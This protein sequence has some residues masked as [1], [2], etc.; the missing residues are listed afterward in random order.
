MLLVIALHVLAVV[1]WVGGMA[2]ALFILRP[3]LAALPPPQRLAVLARVFARFLPVVGAAVLVIVV[4]GAWLVL[5]YGGLRNA[6]WGVHAMI[7]IGLVMIAVY[8]WVAVRLN[9]RLQ[10]AVRTADWPAGGAAA[11]SMRRWILLNLALGVVVIVA[12]IAGRAG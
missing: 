11:E 2:F 10:A 8:A 3:G 12:G 9:P 4:T 7:A 6:P 5:Q 1:L